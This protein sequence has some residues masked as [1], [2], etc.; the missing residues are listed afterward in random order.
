[1][2][3]PEIRKGQAQ[4]KGHDTEKVGGVEKRERLCSA[5]L[6]SS[7]CQNGR[8]ANSPKRGDYFQN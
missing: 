8:H 4:K 7:F 6:G 3:K 1:M 2:E 5:V